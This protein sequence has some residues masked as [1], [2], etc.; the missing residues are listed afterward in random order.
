MLLTVVCLV[1]A[2][3]FA[4]WRVVR[5]VRHFLHLFQL[6]GYKPAAYLGWL[7]AHAGLVVRSSH[8][9]GLGLLG[10][11]GVAWRVG[12]VEALAPVVLAGWTLAFLSS[13]HVRPGRA[14]KPL[15]FTSRMTRLAAAAGVLAALLVAGGAA[16]GGSLG[17]GQ[18]LGGGRLVVAVGPFL[19]ALLAADLGAPG[20][21]LLGALA[22][23]PVETAIQ[24]GFKRQARRTLA[25]RRDLT[26]VA[27]TGSFGKTSTKFILAELLRQKYSVL[28][29]P[30]SYNTPMGVCLVVNEKLRPEHQV[31]VLEMGI[32]HPGDIAELCALAPPDLGVVTTVGPAHLETMG[33]LDAI[34]EE[35]GSLVTFTDGPVILNLDNAYTARMDARASGRAWYV[36]AE[37]H[38]EADIT[39]HAVRYDTSGATFRVRD[40]T[41][42]EAVFRTK[43]LGQHNV[44]NI[45]LAVAV[46][47]ALGLR[48]RAMAHAIRRVEPVEHRL[49]LR[50]E[51]AVTVIDDAFNANPV[52]A[53]N[54][55]E[56]LAQMDSGR[57]VIV[58]PG[59]VELGAAQWD[60]NEAFGRT[61][62]R[63]DLDHVVL[64][65]AEQTA[66]IQAGLRAEGFPDEHLTVAPSLF[67]ARDFLQTYLQPGDVVL[68]E[69]DL[70]DQYD[71]G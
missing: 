26:V 25:R 71:G 30:S 6:E 51:G 49:A 14:K 43:L 39:A 10:M 46:G 11:W 9:A 69:N 61:I 47:R 42:A 5:R 18:S 31:L 53:R 12:W 70:P 62:A 16:L 1:V 17:G 2:S 8:V 24:N 38:P 36:S 32:R 65:G 19:A 58:T 56:I 59:M 13:K 54:A 68:Y 33:S 35:K 4:G 50:H 20:L 40:E 55:V 48:L 57:R 28:A 52:G 41:G 37:G 21:V 63:H 3:L 44:L 64:V 15:R 7:G 66:P 29:T 67:A 22:M 45:L 27:I 23:Q 60:E 34:A